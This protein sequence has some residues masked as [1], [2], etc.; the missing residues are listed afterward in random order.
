MRFIAEFKVP[1]SHKKLIKDSV[2]S[3]NKT[4]QVQLLGDKI[5]EAFGWNNLSSDNGVHH[6]LEIEAFPMDKWVEFKQ[7]LF[8]HLVIDGYEISPDY[9]RELVK[10]LESFGKPAGEAK[11]QLP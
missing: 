1:E 3:Y 5:E 2:I 7:K 10:E 4:I 8:D 6:Q 9:L 11:G